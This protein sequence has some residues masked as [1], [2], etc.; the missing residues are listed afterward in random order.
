M[1]SSFLLYKLILYRFKESKLIMEKLFCLKAVS[2]KSATDIEM[3]YRFDDI[4]EKIQMKI[5][6]DKPTDRVKLIDIQVPDCNLLE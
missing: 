4:E 5:F 2:L 6:Y 1:I 3:L